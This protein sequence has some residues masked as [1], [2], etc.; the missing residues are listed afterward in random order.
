MTVPFKGDP[1]NQQ[2]GVIL[3]LGR[4]LGN[5]LSG[6]QFYVQRAVARGRTY[7]DSWGAVND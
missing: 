4:A 6:H 5:V 3:S 2:N 1:E 7:M